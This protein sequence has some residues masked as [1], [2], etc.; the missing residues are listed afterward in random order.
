[1]RKL[2]YSLVVILLAQNVRYVRPIP[3][4]LGD[5]SS[6]ANAISN[7]QINK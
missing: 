4:G 1:M 7:Q 3:Y 6:W 5:G 2:L